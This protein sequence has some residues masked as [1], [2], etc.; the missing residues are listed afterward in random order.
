MM[1]MMLSEMLGL[2]AS[3]ATAA[4]ADGTENFQINGSFEYATN[5]DIPDS[6]SGA[7]RFYR[8]NG[9]PVEICDEAGLREFR[10]K[11]FLDGSNAVHGG[12]SMRVE[13]PF[14][15]LGMPMDVPNGG[16]Y[17]VSIHLRAEHAGQKVRFAVT[18]RDTQALEGET[19]VAAGPEWTRHELRLDPYPHGAI[20]VY[21]VPLDA[22]KIW[23]DAVQ[24]EAGS[25]ATP[26]RPSRYDAGSALP[27][28]VV[29]PRP[30][31]TEAPMMR[32][33]APAATPP[34]LDGLADDPIWKDVP[35]VVMNDYMG[36]PA[37]VPTSIR[38]AYDAQALYLH[39]VCGD[40][41]GARGL[42][43]TVEI[44]LDV[45][46]IGDPFYQFVFDAQGAKHNFRSLRGLHEWEWKAD[47]RVATRMG[48]GEWTAEVAIPFSSLPDTATLAGL[49]ALRMNVC[50]NY[51]P[52]PEKYL[53]WAPVNVGFLEPENFGHVLLGADAAT[54][55]VS[56]LALAA[57]SGPDSR[58]TL[59]VAAAGPALK[60]QRVN[61]SACVEEQGEAAQM[62]GAAFEHRPGQSAALSFSGI[63]LA[64][65]R[66]RVTLL[67]TDADGRTIKQVRQFIDVP[68]PL[69]LYTEYSYY[70]DETEARVAVRI[71][72]ARALPEDAK[73]ALT[74]RV[75]GYPQILAEKTVA[76][77]P[78]GGRQLV[79]IPLARATPGHIFDL[80]GRL[81]D[82]AGKELARGT[83]KLVRHA[84]NP[85]EVKV[86]RLNRGLYLNGEPF[87]PYG[88]LVSS[89]GRSQLEYYK[90]AGFD[91]I[92]FISHWGTPDEGLA[93]LA[94]C[95]QL[96]INAVAFHVARPGR[97]APPDAAKA[98]RDARSLVGFTPNDEESDRQVYDIA[99]RNQLA[100][101][102]VL[103]GINHNFTSYR[104]FA[105]RLEGFPG[106]ALSID[107]YPL[108]GLPK[109]RPHTTSE[110]YSVERCIEIMDR[111]GERERM[112]S[113]FWLQA[114]ER[115]S[116]EPTPTELTWL[117]YI[118]LVNRCM[119]FT[120]FG[121]MP[122]SR[123]AWERMVSLNQEMRQLKPYLFSFEPDPEIRFGDD[124]SRH[125]IRVLPKILG[126]ELVLICVKR[127]REPVE[128]AIDLTKVERLSPGSATAMFED[129][130][131][132]VGADRVLK[133]RFEPLERHVYKLRLE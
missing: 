45:L 13:R 59:A 131:V 77:A 18:P 35:A 124:A 62:R 123:H 29:H 36:A 80:D 50:R 23:V 74:L 32:L 10:E 48:E 120:Y 4:H 88:I 64:A 81:L 53:S 73:L 7:G 61:V 8:S 2:A 105:N 20:S 68:H 51:A 14:H 63:K 93:F 96:G 127:A 78:E 22:G 58:F 30:G 66:C 89:Y 39:L 121:G 102:Y 3:G 9:L 116:K 52:G 12:R 27:Q 92:S 5:P 24:I 128:A 42:R 103:N 126:D 79:S 106:D 95:E 55:D 101:P 70:T 100:N 75:A 133:D 94:N 25:A 57:E 84:P 112:P 72:P 115:F 129:R 44:F 86:N 125:Y 109:G 46:G 76:A 98:Y 132:P 104:A 49:G 21:V 54:L 31:A 6:W 17:V 114:G 91:F 71:E 38:V 37:T 122:S 16:G 117:N 90:K 107:R 65:T 11:F 69:R 40:P 85:T 47:W 113:L 33:A 67:F 43:D 111:D 119:G 19:V 108:L 87:L 15:L 110:I 34:T 28:P 60:A 97:T 83:T 99:I 130:A 41:G 1:A 26:F 56:G 118:L 82:G